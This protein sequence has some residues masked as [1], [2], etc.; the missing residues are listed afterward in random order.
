MKRGRV[1]DNIGDIPLLLPK[2]KAPTPA[3]SAAAAAALTRAAPWCTGTRPCYTCGRSGHWGNDCT[4]VCP[5][6]G[7]IGHGWG[8][9]FKSAL[10]Y[11]SQHTS[12]L[13]GRQSEFIQAQAHEG[14][15]ALHF[16][17]SNWHD[18]P[19]RLQEQLRAGP[20]STSFRDLTVSLQRTVPP[21]PGICATA[22]AAPLQRTEAPGIRAPPLP[23]PQ[24]NGAQFFFQ[25]GAQVTIYTSFAP[26]PH[27][28]A[29]AHAFTPGAAGA[30]TQSPPTGAQVTVY[31]GL[32]Q[33]DGAGA[34]HTPMMAPTPSLPPTTVVTSQP[35]V[36]RGAPSL[37][38]PVVEPTPSPP[39]STVVP[40]QPTVRRGAPSPFSLP[41][42]EQ[43]F[44]PLPEAPSPKAPQRDHRS[45][46]DLAPEL[47]SPEAAEPLVPAAPRPTP[48]VPA[49][50]RAAPLV[51]AA[52]RPAPLVPAA[53]RPAPLVPAA[54]RAAQAPAPP[55][56]AEA[57][58]FEVLT[59]WLIFLYQR[60]S[61]GAVHGQRGGSDLFVFASALIRL[62]AA[63]VTP[64][65][66]TLAIL[67][68]VQRK[69]TVHF[70]ESLPPQG[71]GND[72]RTQ[73]SF[74]AS[75]V[76]PTRA[77]SDATVGYALERLVADVAA[78]PGAA[79]D[80]AAWVRLL[81]ARAPPP[82]T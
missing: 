1:P 53:P 2:T 42:T 68:L 9:C 57:F 43:S 20:Y 77:A 71:R 24:S 35:T 19:P 36:R 65:G 7:A 50:P 49:A 70:R 47:K 39:P 44:S 59:K 13:M 31:N 51:P 30:S 34:L 66:A 67:S 64:V 58:S 22:A 78:K 76:D 46:F 15:H 25:A 72:A 32:A 41:P 17:R 81:R 79:H 74:W 75:Y 27:L 60:G 80:T 26:P 33:L 55:P 56:P 23:V 3:A 37:A 40:S 4:M 6:C 10:G 38:S 52:P 14:L 62:R 48:L 18:L 69:D 12:A 82:E 29:G 8:S 16:L 5:L 73:A 11:R 63:S 21:R 61:R 45:P 28:G 54:P